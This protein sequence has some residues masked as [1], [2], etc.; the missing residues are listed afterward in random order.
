MLR[1]IDFESL[2]G[3]SDRHGAGFP[4]GR[5]IFRENDTS[6]EFY[7]I[8]Q[9]SVELSVKNPATG[10]KNVLL[11][12][13][14]GGFFG[15]MSAFGGMPRSATAVAAED[16]LLL[17][18]NQDTAV[19]LIRASPRFALGVI[20]TLCDRIRNNN[21]RITKL[22]AT[23]TDQPAPTSPA[24][25]SA[26]SNARAAMGSVI[27][28]ARSAR[29]QPPV[30]EVP[31]AEFDRQTLFSKT[32]SCPGCRTRFVSLNV[33]PDAIDLR[34][35]DS[36]FHEIHGGP[37][38]LWY[39]IYVCP[40]CRFAAYPDDF[41]N[42][43]AQ[44][45]QAIASQIAARQALAE[46]LVLYG[47]RDI[48]AARVAFQL[49]VDSYALRARCSELRAPSSEHRAPSTERLATWWSISSAS[50]VGTREPRSHGRAGI[51]TN[52]AGPV[53]VYHEG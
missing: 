16:S 39:Q 26:V 51:L 3:L 14:V 20:Q 41:A 19:N 52:G 31:P 49:A 1:N 35:R 47:E 33:R 45:P 21:E 40:T 48:A 8:L 50:L 27:S 11:T 2:K 29:V 22:T 32:L 34:S 17:F 9:G 23:T 37:N 13:Q 25:A 36:D 18:F 6:A 46:G 43:V 42:L 44:E 12:V 28:A 10:Q 53:D 7:V 38:P 24:V 4:R 15:E 5:V 30:C